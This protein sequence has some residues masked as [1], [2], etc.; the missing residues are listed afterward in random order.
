MA[1]TVRIERSADRALERL[2]R[3][4]QD[5]AGSRISPRS[6]AD[7]SQSGCVAVRVSGR[8]ASAE[9]RAVYRISDAALEVHVIRI[10]PRS[11]A[12]RGL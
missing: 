7:R 4:L 6:R 10:A 9:Y 8:A 11:R 5:P 2:P 3:N 12:Y 1:Y